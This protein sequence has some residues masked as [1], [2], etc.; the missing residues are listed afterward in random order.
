MYSLNEYFGL[1]SSPAGSSSPT[2]VT[3]LVRCVPRPQK[4]SAHGALHRAVADQVQE[5]LAV[6]ALVPVRSYQVWER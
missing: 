5:L 3:I 2:T 1:I 6:N 4:H